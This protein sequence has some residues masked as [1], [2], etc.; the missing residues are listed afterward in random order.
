MG[1]LCEIKSD[2]KFESEDIQEI[3]NNLPDEYQRFGQKSSWEWSLA[4]DLKLWGEKITVSGSY[5]ISGEIAPK[6]VK[7]MRTELKKRGYQLKP[8]KWLW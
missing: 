4:C 3:V 5:G 2:R 6:F 8:N 1:Y 7:H